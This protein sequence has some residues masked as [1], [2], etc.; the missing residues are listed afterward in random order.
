[1][2][3]MMLKTELW[4]FYTRYMERL[5]EQQMQCTMDSLITFLYSWMQAVLV[6]TRQMAL[7]DH[8]AETL[9]A[10]NIAYLQKPA[11]VL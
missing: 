3:M 5:G 9:F 4:I 10:G 1:M 8:E 6:F 2:M 7:Q 11:K